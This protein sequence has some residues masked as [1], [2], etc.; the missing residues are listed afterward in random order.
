MRSQIQDLSR[1]MSASPQQC[2]QRLEHRRPPGLLEL[3]LAI[4]KLGKKELEK[5]RKEAGDGF[6][7]AEGCL[8]AVTSSC[9]Q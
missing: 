8:C 1:P 9:F 5:Q 2:R 4:I 7:A 3:V 6:E